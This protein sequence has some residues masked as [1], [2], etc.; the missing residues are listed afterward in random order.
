MIIQVKLKI[1]WEKKQ[2]NYEQMVK[3]SLSTVQEMKM[4]K[5]G[6]TLPSAELLVMDLPYEKKSII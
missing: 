3:L 2:H 6:M 5:Y 4:L 1:T